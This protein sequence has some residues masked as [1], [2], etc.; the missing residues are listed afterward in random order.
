MRKMMRSPI[1][2]RIIL[3][4]ICIAA[5]FSIS[6][7]RAGPF[8]LHIVTIDEWNACANAGVCPSVE[9]DPG[10]KVFW[11]T[12]LLPRLA[13]V[14]GNQIPSSIP[15]FEYAKLYVEWYN[16]H[17]PDKIRMLLPEDLR[18]I[19]VQKYMTGTLFAKDMLDSPLKH[20]QVPT[21]IDHCQTSEN[22]HTPSPARLTQFGLPR[23]WNGKMADDGTTCTNLPCIECRREMIQP[24]GLHSQW[25]LSDGN[26]H[27]S[28]LVV[29]DLY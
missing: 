3:L 5:L 20:W 27:S 10:L 18:S 1:N 21:W 17:S 28:H 29:V 19:D 11:E 25:L 2:A 7:S 15:R 6:S 23:D 8:S 13:A 14:D 12:G 16:T 4:Y 24:S 22:Y 26:Y 9:Q